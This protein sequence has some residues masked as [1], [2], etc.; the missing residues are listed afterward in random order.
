MESS[1]EPIL[2]S[3]CLLG[4]KCRHDGRDSLDKRIKRLSSNVP[5]V[6]FCP[7]VES[8][9]SIPREPCEIMG[10]DGCDVLDNKARVLAEDGSDLSI[11]YLEG[12]RVALEKAKLNCA[13]RA[14]LKENSPSCGAT[15][16]YDGTF[17]GLLRPGQG[18][19][20]AMLRRWG[21][22]VSSDEYLEY[23]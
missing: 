17:K 23:Y 1:A 4:E 5:M 10:G 11:F 14:I 13:K 12:A 18:V 16:I 22:K 6:V 20:A 9:L 2:V 19:T 8:G 3:A 21:L 7:E 15:N